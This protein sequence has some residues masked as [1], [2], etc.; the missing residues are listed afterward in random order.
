MES[1]QKI[2][3]RYTKAL[4]DLSEL[5]GMPQEVIDDTM[6]AI[7]GE[8]NEKA[9]G[10]SNFINLLDSDVKAID[11]EIARLNARKKAIKNKSDNFR[12]YLLFNMQKS[13]INKIECPYFTISTVKG[14]ESVIVDDVDQLPDDCVT[15][16]LTVTPDK[17]AIKDQIKSGNEINGARIERGNDTLRIK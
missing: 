12:N 15:T 7:E 4:S 14:R 5:E 8:F 11:D 2:S 3:E 9:V 13:G 6:S 1:L 16:K 10:V 17:K